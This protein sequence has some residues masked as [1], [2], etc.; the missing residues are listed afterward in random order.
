MSER[1]IFVWT[2]SQNFK[3]LEQV[4]SNSK[5]FIKIPQNT[6]NNHVNTTQYTNAFLPA[7]ISRDQSEDA[8]LIAYSQGERQ[9]PNTGNIIII[10]HGYRK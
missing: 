10:S 9:T 7:K 3:F 4:S 1:N 8:L 2:E 6:S 5:L